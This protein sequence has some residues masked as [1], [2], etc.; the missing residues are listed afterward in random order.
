MATGLILGGLLACE[1]P[2]PRPASLDRDTGIEMADRVDSVVR[3]ILRR[4]SIEGAAVA[5]VDDGEV[6]LARGYGLA[7]VAAG[8]AL[9]AIAHAGGAPGFAANVRVYLDHDVTVIALSNDERA[10]PQPLT[11][12]LGNILLGFPDTIAP[13]PV[14]PRA[15]Q[16]ALTDGVE[17][18]LEFWDTDDPASPMLPTEDALNLTAYHYLEAGFISEALTLFE[19]QVRVFPGSAN[20]HD[21]LGEGL[22]EAGRDE[23]ARA[24]YATALEIDPDYAN[25]DNARDILEQIDRR[26]AIDDS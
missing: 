14:S 24:A 15:Y 5:L 21:R 7:D 1:P 19:L 10:R 4:D 13:P 2:S 3:R 11:N 9:S 22:L 8:R 18:A 20:A 12:G 23:A 17:S 6:L 16:V 25:A 26:R